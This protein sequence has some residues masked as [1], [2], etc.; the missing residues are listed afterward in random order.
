[1]SSDNVP[2]GVLLTLP[3]DFSEADTEGE[4]TR[5]KETEEEKS[6]TMS[7]EEIEKRIT[8]V[9]DAFRPFTDGTVIIEPEAAAWSVFT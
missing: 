1:M 3:P 4:P 6:A 7:A 9:E 5:G 2:S 8:K